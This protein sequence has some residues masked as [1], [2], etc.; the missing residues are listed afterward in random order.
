MERYFMG[1]KSA[2]VKAVENLTTNA[3]LHQFELAPPGLMGVTA[4]PREAVCE[5][6]KA[7]QSPLFKLVS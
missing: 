1:A 6:V 2:S 5:L 7:L 4:V 3:E